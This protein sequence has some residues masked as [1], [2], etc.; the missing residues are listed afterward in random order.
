MVDRLSTAL[1]REARIRKGERRVQKAVESAMRDLATMA[2]AALDS[3]SMDPAVLDERWP[4]WLAVLHEQVEPVLADIFMEAYD[5]SLTAAVVTPASDAATVHLA[6]VRNRMVGIADNVFSLVTGALDEGRLAEEGIP[7]LA[8]RV[9]A[10]LAAEGA[11]TWANRGRTVARTEV[12]AA[13]NA[14]SHA[15]AADVAGT[16]GTAT[17]D[18]A[19]EWLAT[20]D[21]RTRES[22][23]E[24]DGQ[25][26]F[27]LDTPFEVGGDLLE[28]PGDPAGSPEEV[29]NC[30]CTV[31]YH[32]PG[33][34]DY[35]TELVAEP[36][37]PPPISMTDEAL[38]AEVAERM[39]AGDFTSTRAT[40]LMNELDTRD[41]ENARVIELPARADPSQEQLALNRLLFGDADVD[42]LAPRAVRR[43]TEAQMV[44]EWESW[45]H[46]QWMRAEEATRGNLMTRDAL[47]KGYH[48]EDVINR[49]ISQKWATQ[50][51]QEWLAENPSMSFPEYRSFFMDDR[52]AREAAWRLRNRG[53]ESEYG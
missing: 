19:K 25:M 15:A 35:P 11:Q 13:A 30:R 29:I 3:S 49:R 27:G 48:P 34:P 26:V 44:D 37:Q 28:Y 31:L 22:H 23:A 24:A 12:I 39:A 5:D 21:D 42:P 7:D 47:A 17:G 32:H 10:T 4:D 14:G 51:F 36:D 53:Y 43:N 38:E 33:D 6:T 18:V 46:V 50:E 52:R 40:Q 8:K 20:A 9:D 45:V 2:V 1:A 16:L 41:A